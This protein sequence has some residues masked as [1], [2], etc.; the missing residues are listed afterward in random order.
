MSHWPFCLFH[1]LVVFF[2]NETFSTILL[3]ISSENAFISLWTLE[4]NIH[5]YIIW[6]L[7]AFSQYLTSLSV[8]GCSKELEAWRECGSLD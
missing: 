5:S 2:S 6:I 1:E 8:I 3:P 7:D 4:G